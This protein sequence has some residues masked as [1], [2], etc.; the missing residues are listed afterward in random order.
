MLLQTDTP[1][2]ACYKHELIKKRAYEQRVREVERGSFTPFVMSLTGGLGNAAILI[3]YKKHSHL[4]T[5]NRTATPLPGL[6]AACHSHYYAR[7][8]NALEV[9]TSQ[10][11]PSNISFHPLTLCR[12]KN[13]LFLEMFGS[14]AFVI[15][16]III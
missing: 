11:M 7:Q 1:L 2:P 4:N 8:S 10:V 16:I 13:V 6:G 3:C 9:L 5:T 15:I 14:S 12:I